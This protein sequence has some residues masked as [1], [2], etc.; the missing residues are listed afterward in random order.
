MPSGSSPF[1]LYNWVLGSTAAGNMTVV[2]PAS[3]VIGQSGAITVSTSGL[4][5]AT[6]YLGSVVYSGATGMPNPTIVRIDTP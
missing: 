4:A 1:K 3:A 5:A 6:K 2:A